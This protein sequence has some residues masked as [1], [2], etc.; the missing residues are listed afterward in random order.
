MTT[1]RT[2]LATLAATS[3]ALWLSPALNAEEGDFRLA[4][5]EA[6]ITPPLGHPLLGGMI[7]EAKTIKE[8]LLAR[9]MILLSSEQPLVIAALDWCELR[10][11][12]Y[13]HFRDAIAKAA[14]TS[15][16]RVLLSCI[17]QHDAPYCDLTAQKLLT[18][19]G[20]EKAMFH[21]E[22]FEQAVTAVAAAAHKSL[23]TTNP[24]TQVATAAAEVERIACNRRVELTPGKP[25]FSRYS[26]TSDATVRN[27][28]EGA[29]DSQLQTLGFYNADKLLATLS[30]YA[31]HPM[32]YYGKGE[33]SYDF[34]GMART[35]LDSEQPAVFHM[36]V[37][38]CSGDVVAAKF[39]EGN[40]ASRL[41]LAERLATAMSQSIKRLEP[42]PLK[43]LAFRNVPLELP[44]PNE[45]SFSPEQ[46]Q[47]KIDDSALGKTARITAALGLSYALRCKQRPQIDLPAIDFG[48]ASYLV[49]PA[50]MFVEYQLAARKLSGG[51]PLLVAGFGEC[52]PGYIPTEQARREG[53][54]EEH[55]YCWNKAGAEAAILKAVSKA[56]GSEGK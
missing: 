37:S 20:M 29:I 22:F 9:G 27:A 18:A 5:F 40:E 23:A 13:D 36:Y 30:V 34:P 51:H 35:M 25:N 47:A 53:F 2:A 55:S 38:G 56:L 11:D 3:A 31:V 6:D 49:L 48:A 19:A 16:E 39:N 24:C 42:Q 10:N 14:N 44:P 52:A 54:V 8:Q 12:A 7:Q 45:G 4:T 50:E 33:V 15:R 26:F 32:S 1:R 17:H 46:L 41:A 21:Q 28:P 43:Q